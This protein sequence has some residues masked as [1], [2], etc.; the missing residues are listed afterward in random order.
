ME[1]R[2]RLVTPQE[3]LHGVEPGMS[4]FLGT[5]AGE[6]RTLVQTLVDSREG[7]LRDLELVQLVSLGDALNIDELSHLK[8]RLKT[9]YSGWVAGEAITE[10]HV[11]LILSRF[12]RIP[13]L[14][15]E[16]RVVV[17]AAFLQVSPPNAS[18]YVSLGVS[19]DVCREA[20][21][22]A[23]LVIGEINENVPCTFG[24]TFVHMDSFSALVPGEDGPLHFPRWPLEEAFDRLAQNVASVVEDGSCLAFSIGP[25]FEGLSKHLG[26]KKDLGIHSAF[27]TDAVRDLVESGAVTN[28]RKEIFRGKS[29][30]SYALGTSDLL[31][32]LDRNPLVEFQG[33]DKT[34]SP[35]QAGRNSDFVAILPARRVDLSGRIALHV[36]KGNVS[37][38]PG[39]ALDLFNSAELSDGG[40]TIV[41]LPARNRDGHPN[42]RVNIEDTPNKFS[43]REAVDMVITDHGVA[44]L[45]GRTVR[46][47][48]QALIDVAHPD[49]RPALV[50]QAR[51][52]RIIYRDQIFIPESA[53]LYPSEV[54]TCHTFSEGLKIRFRALRPSD[55]EGMRRLFYRFSDEAVY[56]RFFS[57]LKTMPHPKMQQYVNVDYR[58][59]MAVVGLVGEPGQ[60]KIIA[61]ARWVVWP[62]TSRADLAFVVDEE[63]GGNGI[64]TYLYRMLARLAQDRGITT[65]TADVLASNRAMMRVIEKGGFAVEAKL[66]EG[67]YHLEIDLS[68][69]SAG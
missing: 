44:S 23:S 43:M 33:L 36:G 56:Y 62:G 9:F 57:A 55:E 26:N 50:E 14:I 17:D 53:K 12:S 15:R 39:E 20:M 58:T 51:Q 22:R 69:A 49:D 1:W 52:A 3:A 67:A 61:E 68:P 30:A 6:P 65:F 40:T 29:V 47:R 11:D 7:N 13:R 25:L 45:G 24:D 60:G 59:T 64:A 8:Y 35:V 48:A 41:A 38:G 21:E 5:G 54:A 42:I 10:G 18:G 63:Y 46:E 34:C 27:F 66:E 31:A 2:S 19:V 16:G 32:W 4:I 28:R 37:A